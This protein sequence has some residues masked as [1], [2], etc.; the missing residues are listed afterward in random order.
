MRLNRRSFLQ[1]S[2]LAGGGFALG[3]YPRPWAAAQA[4]GGPPA[5][6]PLAFIR[7]AANGEI[8]IM[9]RGPEI[10]QGVRTMLP[11]LIAVGVGLT[12]INT[13]AV[14]EALFGI[15]S[16]FVRTPKFAIGE[17]QV[18]LEHKK[19]RRRSFGI[20]NLNSIKRDLA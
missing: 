12:I 5:L 9:A 3:L 13:R 10:G 7:I 20:F 15:E 17:R 11:M 16:G 4:A 18:S 6:S 2:A 1:L 14:L 8:T 19:Y